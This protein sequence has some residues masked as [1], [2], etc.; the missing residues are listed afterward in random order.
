MSLSNKLSVKDLD[1]AGK[2]VFIRVDFNV[3]L[4]V[5]LSPTTKELLLLCQPSNTL[6]NINQ[7]TLSWLP[8]WVDQTVKETTNTH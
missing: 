5:R 7:N 6:K 8:T 4:T 3:P 1:V 2:R